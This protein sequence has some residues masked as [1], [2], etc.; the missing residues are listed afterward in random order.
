MFNLF[1]SKIEFFRFWQPLSS[2]TTDYQVECLALKSDFISFFVFDDVHSR[3][4][5]ER[6]PNGCLRFRSPEVVWRNPEAAPRRERENVSFSIYTRRSDRWQAVMCILRFV[7]SFQMR[8]TRKDCRV[9]VP[10][11]EY[12]IREKT[13]SMANGFIMCVRSY[14]TLTH[15][16]RS[17]KHWLVSTGMSSTF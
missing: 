5:R 9:V 13:N 1:R 11:V 10:I 16:V 14:H 6:W 12:L 8:M 4:E 3:A 17:F 2:S 7:N 15:T